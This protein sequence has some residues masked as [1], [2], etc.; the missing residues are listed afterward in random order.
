[1]CF[2]WRVYCITS[3]FSFSHDLTSDHLS[4]LDTFMQ[5]IHEFCDDPMVFNIHYH[6][7]NKDLSYISNVSSMMDIDDITPSSHMNAIVTP[8][9]DISLTCHI[10]PSIY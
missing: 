4:L 8:F 10:F 9:D 3:H 6:L 2:P 7:P 1:M 5:F